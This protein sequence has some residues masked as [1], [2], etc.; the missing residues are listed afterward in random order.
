MKFV[1][2]RY[3]LEYPAEVSR[4]KRYGAH[5]SW[6]LI[7]IEKYDAAWVHKAPKVYQVE[8]HTFKKVTAINES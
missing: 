1:R 2:R 3:L 5:D 4:A 6:E 8:E 7:V